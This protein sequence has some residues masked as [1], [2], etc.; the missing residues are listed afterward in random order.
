MILKLEKLYYVTFMYYTNCINDTVSNYESNGHDL[1]RIEYLTVGA[2]PFLLRESDLPKYQKFGGGYREIKFV[3]NIPVSD[4]P[5]D[6]MDCNS[7]SSTNIIKEDSDDASEGSLTDWW[8][9]QQDKKV[10]YPN[11][12]F[13]GVPAEATTAQS[14]SDSYITVTNM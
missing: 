3:G 4:T 9:N 5:S 6:S 7:D 14:E 1:E 11:P 2:E 13:V 8:K 12:H 10:T